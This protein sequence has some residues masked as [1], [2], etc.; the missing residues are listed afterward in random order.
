MEDETPTTSQPTELVRSIAEKCQQLI[1][2]ATVG[3]ITKSQF[4]EHI[5]E[6]GASATEAQDYLEQL[7]Q[8]LQQPHCPDHSRECSPVHDP[9][10]LERESTPDG[11]EGQALANF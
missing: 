3:F 7:S 5:K 4:L 9:P 10:S 2:Q 1:D 8:C 6:L 11:L